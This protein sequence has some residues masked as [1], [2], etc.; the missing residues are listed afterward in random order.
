MICPK[1]NTE[2]FCHCKNC[3]KKYSNRTPILWKII[4][5]DGE[6]YEVEYC[7]NCGYE[8]SPNFWEDLSVNQLFEA[9]NVSSFKELNEKRNS[10]KDRE[11]AKR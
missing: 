5:E 11:K 8:N 9:E 1:C 10:K 4:L 2:L 7:G 6:E 3:I